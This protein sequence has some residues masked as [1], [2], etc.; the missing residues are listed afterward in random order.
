MARGEA[1]LACCGPGADEESGVHVD[2]PSAGVRRADERVCE[3][4]RL[5]EAALTP[6]TRIQ[7]HRDDRKCAREDGLLENA[8]GK[9]GAQ[10]VGYRLD[11]VILQQVEQRTQ[12]S[13]V[14]AMSDGAVKVRRRNAARAAKIVAGRAVFVGKGVGAECLAAGEA[15]KTRL[16]RQI[17][18]A[19]FANRGAGEAQQGRVADGAGC[20]KKR[21]AEMAGEV[22]ERLEWTSKDA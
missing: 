19:G 11:A 4:R 14:K 22:G 3:Q 5:V 12:G 17:A 2:G 20:R 10:A 18:P 1:G 6:L 7:R 9:Q 21:A 15:K 13:S 16:W 8:A